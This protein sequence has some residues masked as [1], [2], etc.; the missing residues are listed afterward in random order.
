MNQFAKRNECF[1]CTPSVQLQSWGKARL[2]L[3][4]AGLWC[5]CEK[6]KNPIVA[7]ATPRLCL[8]VLFPLQVLMLTLQNDPP[9]L[10]TGIEDKEMM[11]KYGKSFRK[12]LSLC[13]QKDPSKRYVNL[14]GWVTGPGLSH[15]KA[16]FVE[17]ERLYEDTCKVLLVQG[18]CCSSPQISNL[19]AED[20][21]GPQGKKGMGAGERHRNISVLIR[22]AVL[23]R[24]GLCHQRKWSKAE[25][26]RDWQ[27][28]IQKLS[29]YSAPCRLSWPLRIWISCKLR[30]T[31][32]RAIEFCMS[33]L[34]VA[35]QVVCYH[36]KDCWS[37][38][39]IFLH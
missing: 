3:I 15:H 2:Y 34:S 28:C 26:K 22:F 20:S 17:G 21:M 9:T 24:C 7:I 31:P 16:L 6:T 36:L 27:W 8:Y 4:Q 32:G 38:S 23:G 1:K 14:G 18:K 10:E 25:M 30:S 5:F 33:F 29:S 37:R 13:L 12:L 19:L 39:L 11:K 35:E